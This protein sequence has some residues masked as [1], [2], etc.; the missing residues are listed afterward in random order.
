MAVDDIGRA[1]RVRQRACGSCAR[2]CARWRGIFGVVLLLVLLATVASILAT[3]GL[4]LI[5][6]VP[7][8]ARRRVAAA[9]CRVA[10]A[11]LRLSV[12]G[13]DRAR[14]LPDPVS[15]L[16]RRQARSTR[17]SREAATHDRLRRVSLAR[18]RAH[19]RVGHPKMGGVAGA[20]PR[21]RVLRAGLSGAR[22]LRRG[23]DFQ[24][25][26]QELLSGR[27]GSV[28]QYGPT[29]GYRPLLEAIAGIMAR[30]G[31]RRRRTTAC[32]SRP[33]RSRGSTSSLAC[34]SI[35]TTSS[36]SSC[37]PTPAPSRLSAT[38]RPNMV[39]VP[40]E[41]DGI[42][43]GDLDDTCERLR[44]ARDAARALLYLVPNFQ[45]PT[46]L[47]IGLEK[48]AALLEWA[49]RRDVL[50]VEDD[51]VS[52]PV[53]RGLGDRGGRAA[54]RG[55]RSLGPRHLLEQLFEDAGARLSRR[56]DRC[57]A[58]ARGQD[59]AGEAG[60]GPLHRR[61]RPAC[62]VRGLPPRHARSAGADPARA[63]SAQA[64]RDGRGPA[65]RA[66]RATRRGPIPAAGSSCGRRCRRRSMP[67]R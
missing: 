27:D 9:D 47:L 18:R 22:D 10:A 34:C 32:L 56:V 25:I 5:A 31:A 20:G 23:Q 7:L 57:A 45:N 36:W 59:R 26:A 48:R 41:A 37:R 58:A 51:P 24:A 2:A 55:R 1:Q 49:E 67:M 30:R 16:S 29:R 11:R 54:D 15:S 28:L 12:P 65:A 13:A 66:R 40:Q 60:G 35:R 44:R 52:R 19:E 17:S 21:H 33:A 4:G 61:A 6:F 8:V 50:I 3:A 64:R 42:D 43:L 39:G 38:C 14:W 46:G 63:L 53:L 62:R